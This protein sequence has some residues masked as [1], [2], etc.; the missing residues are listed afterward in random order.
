[1]ALET[2]KTTQLIGNLKIGDE[3][4]KSY[5]VNVN[6]EG[7]STIYETVYNADLYAKNRKEMRQQ[8]SEFRTK[9][10]ELE[11]AILAEIESAAVEGK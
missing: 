6:E 4:I 7:V 8:E 2:I 1:M 3:I 5:T 11:D 10:Y 9:R